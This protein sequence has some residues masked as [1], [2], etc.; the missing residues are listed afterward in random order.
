MLQYRTILH[1]P[2]PCT[3]ENCSPYPISM[4]Q[5]RTA[6]NYPFTTYCID[7]LSLPLYHVTVQNHYSL[8][9]Y[10]VLYIELLS[11]PLY[12]VTVQNCSS[13]LLCHVLCRTALLALYHLLYR[14]ALPTTL[15]CIQYRTATPYP[16]TM[17]QYTTAAPYP[18]T[19]YTVQN[20]YSLYPS[21][22][23]CT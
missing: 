19:M 5:Y 15:P 4:L 22:L 2:L 14:S 17:L 12:H 6:T 8:S 1:I 21:T 23:Y 11:L 10:H 7:L 3:V 9:L 16:F 18:F 20:C 13:L